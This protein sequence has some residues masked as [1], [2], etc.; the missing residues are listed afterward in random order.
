MIACRPMHRAL[1]VSMA[2][3]FVS[4]IG[5]AGSPPPKS[6]AS[7]LLAKAMPGF[8]LEPLNGST[9]DSGSF[10]GR[11]LVLSFVAADC[12]AC[13][14]T[15]HAAQEVYSGDR[16]LVVVAVFGSDRETAARLSSKH[17]V[18][19]PVAVD[20]EG[21][22]ARR[23]EVEERPRTFVVDAQGRVR[24]VGGAALTEDSLTAAVQ[25]SR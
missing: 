10:Y 17:G 7:P 13:D 5:C 9:R 16:D 24:W 23:F 4:L 1:P 8:E 19:F 3:L 12:A 20:G 14:Q 6:E 21:L 25:A 15:L 2:L 22:V 18:K 11:T